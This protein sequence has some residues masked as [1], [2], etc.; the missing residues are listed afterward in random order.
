MS[1]LLP[2]ALPAVSGKVRT[3]GEPE[4]AVLRSSRWTRWARS[5]NGR[6]YLKARAARPEERAKANERNQRW[7]ESPA[8][9][10]WMERN[11]AK[12][13]EYYMLRYYT[14]GGRRREYLNEK[15]RERRARLKAAA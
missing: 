11:R 2:K 7:R 9:K 8:G 6:A 5:P 3:I 12:R 14:D 1:W 4:P 15:Q 10:A 13:N